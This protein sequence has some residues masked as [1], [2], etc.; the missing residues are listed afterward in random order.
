MSKLTKSE[1][2]S[3]G[4]KIMALAKKYRESHPD[5]KWTYCVAMAGKMYKKLNE[6]K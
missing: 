3:A 4:S 5:A 6:K 2:S 1:L